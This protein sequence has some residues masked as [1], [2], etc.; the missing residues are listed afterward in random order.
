MQIKTNKDGMFLYLGQTDGAGVLEQPDIDQDIREAEYDE[1]SEEAKSQPC[2]LNPKREEQWG[3]RDDV[4][5][6]VESEEE[7]HNFV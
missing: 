2:S 6:G 7:R 4:D 1:E 3:Q 5:D